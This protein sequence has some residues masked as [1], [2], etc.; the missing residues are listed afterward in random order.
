MLE[1]R[2]LSPLLA[3]VPLHVQALMSTVHRQNVIVM[4]ACPDVDLVGAGGLF[5][6]DNVQ[7][8]LFISRQTRA[9]VFYNTTLRCWLAG[10]GGLKSSLLRAGT[11]CNVGIDAEFL[12]PMH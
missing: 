6:R 10:Q 2:S 9:V 3:Q 5:L 1:P 8:D 12:A 7:P 11:S 4:S